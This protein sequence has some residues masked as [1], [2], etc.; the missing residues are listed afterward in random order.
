MQTQVIKLN[1][2]KIYS[3]L[4][5]LKTRMKT[6]N[7]LQEAIETKLPVNLLERINNYREISWVKQII[8][9]DIK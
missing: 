6:N 9:L 1:Y 7:Q 5:K 2:S 4:I 8:K 3:L